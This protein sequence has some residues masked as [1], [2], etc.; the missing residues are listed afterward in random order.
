MALRL[1]DEQEQ[2]E[3]KNLIKEVAALAKE[4]F[5]KK[6]YAVE[7]QEVANGLSEAKKSLLYI[8]KRSL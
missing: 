2:T 5:E 1:L 6:A 7:W 3:V 4:N 8:K